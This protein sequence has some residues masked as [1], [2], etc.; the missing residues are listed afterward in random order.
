MNL[1]E[2]RCNLILQLMKRKLA[3]SLKDVGL[4]Q[5]LLNNGM[6][7]NQCLSGLRRV[8]HDPIELNKLIDMVNNSNNRDLLKSIELFTRIKPYLVSQ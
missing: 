6:T 5:R 7:F 4:R 2:T 8:V 1:V 3:A